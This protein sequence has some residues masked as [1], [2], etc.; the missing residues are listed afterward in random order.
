MQKPFEK[1]LGEEVAAKAV[2]IKKYAM[3]RLSWKKK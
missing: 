3:R 1:K 2:E